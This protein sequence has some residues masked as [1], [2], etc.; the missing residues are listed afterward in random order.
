MS[1]ELPS[2]LPESS[3]EIRSYDLSVLAS[4]GEGYSP[5]IISTSAGFEH[6]LEYDQKFGLGKRSPAIRPYKYRLMESLEGV[7]NYNWPRSMANYV[8]LREMQ[9]HYTKSDER[10]LYIPIVLLDQVLEVGQ[11][12]NLSVDDYENKSTAIT[13]ISAP[14]YIKGN[15][16]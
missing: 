13:R 6:W 15:D 5:L 2:S 11:T 12:I 10:G 8:I 7:K 4:L 1:S 14:Y 16:D 9:R 3:D